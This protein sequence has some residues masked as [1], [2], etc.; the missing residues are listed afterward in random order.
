MKHVIIFSL[1]AI[2][3]SCGS[4]KT[5]MP[6]IVQ[7]E[8]VTYKMFIEEEGYI[9]QTPAMLHVQLIP[10]DY[11]FYRVQE[12]EGPGVTAVDSL[13]LDPHGKPLMQVSMHDRNKV[14]RIMQED[15]ILQQE[16]RDTF[17][18]PHTY[19]TLF[20]ITQ[21]D[22]VLR[23]LD[24]I[25]YEESMPFLL[26]GQTDFSFFEMQEIGRDS[27]EAH[28]M[29]RE[30]IPTVHRFAAVPGTI[31]EGWYAEGEVL[32]IK[33]KATFSGSTYVYLRYVVEEGT[34]N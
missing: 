6:G 20:T 4:Q 7:A 32:P 31:Y 11:G 5:P 27:T 28:W 26:S 33:W 23:G 21:M 16:G 24:T 10:S 1:F 14:R 9:G 12:L 8:R 13:W 19:P 22:L 34:E 15:A 17:S 2:L 30:Q 18:I 3:V 25:S 29:T